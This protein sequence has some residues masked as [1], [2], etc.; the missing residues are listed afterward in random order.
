MI[1]AVSPKKEQVEETSVAH[2]L[3]QQVTL[4]DLM[5]TELP[6]EDEHDSDYQD[7]AEES[8]YDMVEVAEETAEVADQESEEEDLD[9][10][11]MD[12]IN[13]IVIES[14]ALQGTKILRSGKNVTAVYRES[15]IMRDFGS[16]DE[17]DEDYVEESDEELSQDEHD[18]EEEEEVEETEENEELAVDEV[19]DIVYD[20]VTA[21]VTTLLQPGKVLRHGK[22]IATGDVAEM[23]GLVDQIHQ[24]MQHATAEKTN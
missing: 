1:T 9:E 2:P 15:T 4:V 19:K 22:Q 3:K 12:E 5:E 14:S 8:G 24:M 11:S 13:D 6:S 7:D 10:I 21:P 18:D 23:E 17:E 16:D 20:A